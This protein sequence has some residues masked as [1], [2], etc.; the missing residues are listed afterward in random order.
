MKFLTFLLLSLVSF[1]AM[2]GNVT[3]T[4]TAPTECDDGSVIS[5]CPIT[6]YEIW[7]GSTLTGTLVKQAFQPAATATTA[8][9]TSVAAGQRCFAMKTIA[10]TLTSVESNR[11]CVAVPPSSPKAPTINVTIAIPTAKATVPA[12]AA[13]VAEVDQQVEMPF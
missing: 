5:N 1:G 3:L 10:G 6:G 9:L 4:W 12:P 8:Q 11:V 13:K 2:A 7:M